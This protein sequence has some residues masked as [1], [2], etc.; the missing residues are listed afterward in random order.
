MTEIGRIE[1]LALY[2]GADSMHDARTDLA[3]MTGQCSGDRLQKA[4]AA[5]QRQSDQ[6]R[7]GWRP[8]RR[9]TV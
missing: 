7:A 1:M 9:R 5:V 6:R 4:V 8:F 2:L 3:R